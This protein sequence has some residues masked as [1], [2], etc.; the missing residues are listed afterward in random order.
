MSSRFAIAV[1][2]ILCVLPGSLRAE[3][4]GEYW[5]TAEEEAKYYRIVEIPIPEKMSIWIVSTP[6]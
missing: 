4:L 6:A 1:P 3:P 5:G 2:C